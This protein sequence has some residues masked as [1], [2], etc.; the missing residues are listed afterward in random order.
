MKFYLERFLTFSNEKNIIAKAISV[1]LA[2]ILWAYLNSSQ[3]GRVSVDLPIEY[4]NLSEEFIISYASEN[5]S[6]VTL[7]GRK[8]TLRT[9]DVSSLN[10]YVDLESPR[11]N[12]KWTYPVQL[13]T[14]QMPDTVGVS[15]SVE[16][17]DIMVE[18]KKKMS[19]E[20][21]P[22]FTGDIKDGFVAGRIQIEPSTVEITGPASIIGGI[23][24]I[25]TEP[26]RLDE[27]E[28]GIDRSVSLVTPE[29]SIQLSHSTARIRLPVID[30]EKLYFL[31]IPLVIYSRGDQFDH[32]L[33]SE[34]TRVYLKKDEEPELS[35]SELE[36]FVDMIPIE[37]NMESRQIKRKESELKVNLKPLTDEKDFDIVNYLP[38]TV[39]VISEHSGD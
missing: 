7:E 12:E 14:P 29:N 36:S 24:Y 16:R 25:N 37:E 28:D 21:I 10:L 26:V 22:V 32:F 17:V 4:R 33:S 39:K 31:D 20:V 19:V 6:T 18:E 35:P 5:I 23:E 8:E 38:K 13:D 11:V 27:Q 9:I 2:L 3:V 34:T 30:M 15:F 1:I